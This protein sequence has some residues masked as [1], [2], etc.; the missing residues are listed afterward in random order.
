ME[1]L[2]E[3]SDRIRMLSKHATID[4]FGGI[5]GLIEKLEED[6]ECS[7]C[8]PNEDDGNACCIQY[9]QDEVHMGRKAKRPEILPR[10]IKERLPTRESMAILEKYDNTRPFGWI[11]YIEFHY[12][13]HSDSSVIGGIGLTEDEA[14]AMAQEKSARIKISKKEKSRRL[15]ASPVTAAAYHVLSQGLSD[16]HIGW[17]YYPKVGKMYFYET[18]YEY[19]YPDEET[20]EH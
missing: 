19:R 17:N 8:T 6:I 1:D 12:G 4:D 18:E 14:K 9:I 7:P 5:N 2:I 15:S 3:T 16:S 11:C 10:K 20:T 13:Y